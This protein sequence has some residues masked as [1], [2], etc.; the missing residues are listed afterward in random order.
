MTMARFRNLRPV[1]S[2]KHVIDQQ[3]GTTIDTAVNH[4]LAQTVD[5]PV[6]ANV[7]EVG[8]ACTIN[9]IFLNVQFAINSTQALANFY[10]YV[11][12]NPGSNI[13]AA[14]VPKANA[15]GA[16]DMKKLV[17]HQEMMMGEKN[18][19]GIPRTLFK[20]VLK[21][22]R[23]MRRFGYNDELRIELLSVGTTAE[24]CIQCI[25]KEYR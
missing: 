13:A 8:T 5:A 15:V 16:S 14:Q 1:N 11:W 7:T 3:G 23:H 12:K 25:Y 21:L 4:D 6:L 2:R 18:T 10:M 19:T 22:P 20:G 17:I 9:S 24:Y